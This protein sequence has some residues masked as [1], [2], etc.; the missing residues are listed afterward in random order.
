MAD[1]LLSQGGTFLDVGANHGLLS[2]GLAPR[3]SVSTAF[4]LFEPNPVV[5]ASIKGSLE[6][7]PAMRC[8]VNAIAVSDKAGLVRLLINPDHTG[9]SHIAE[10]G[11]VAVPS[12]PPP[13]NTLKTTASRRSRS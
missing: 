6:L 9:T 8:R 2:F 3:H 1:N 12:I 10:D 4:H 11:G 7:Y 13:L 5:V